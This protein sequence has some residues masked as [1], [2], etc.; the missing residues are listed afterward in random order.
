MNEDKHKNI[1]ATTFTV[2]NRKRTVLLVDDEDLP[3]L[4]RQRSQ[5]MNLYAEEVISQRRNNI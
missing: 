5:M 1:E 3:L 4:Q 2:I